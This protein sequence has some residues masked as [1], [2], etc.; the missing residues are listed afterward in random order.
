MSG[1]L[2]PSELPW[3]SGAGFAEVDTSVEPVPLPLADGEFDDLS[4]PAVHSVARLI[5]RKRQA[6]TLDSW[7][8]SVS[9]LP[10][11]DTQTLILRVSTT[12]DPLTLW[13]LHVH[14]DKRN[15]A[16]CL[17]WPA[18]RSDAQTE[19]VTWTAD[20]LWFAK[21][22]PQHPTLFKGWRRLFTQT[23]G[24]AEWLETAF[25]VYTA[26]AA[27]QNVSSHSAKGLALDH[28]QR[29]TLMTLPTS[30]MVA[31]RQELQPAAF[32]QTRVHLLTSAMENPD[33]AGRHTPAEVAGRRARLWRVHILCGRQPAATARGW[34]SLTGEPLARQVIARQIQTIEAVLKAR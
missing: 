22:N 9:T 31:A 29:Q 4:A 3:R 30:R 24:S 20:V 18:N 10:S 2:T 32:E 16:P 15:I 33:K 12:T 34:V 17:R 5:E 25:R 11:T 6:G 23:P 27:R 14:L 1:G 7:K 8:R 26:F 21:R 19:F 13:A 28:A